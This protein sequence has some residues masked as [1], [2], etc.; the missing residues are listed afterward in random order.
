MVV[1]DTHRYASSGVRTK[2]ISRIIQWF[3]KLSKYNQD[4]TWYKQPINISFLNVILDNW[5][6]VF[7]KTEHSKV[8]IITMWAKEEKQWHVYLSVNRE[9][10][11]SVKYIQRF[12]LIGCDVLFRRILKK[13]VDQ[14][15]S[16]SSYVKVYVKCVFYVVRIQKSILWTV[17]QAVLCI[18]I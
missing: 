5:K 18:D 8:V 11:F 17:C 15:F 9:T 16:T 14:L 13:I 1:T 4:T 7:D 6:N 10:S 3:S 12:V 2:N